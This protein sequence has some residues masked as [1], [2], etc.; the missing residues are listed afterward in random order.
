M[1]MVPYVK[2]EIERR[3]KTDPTFDLWLFPGME[4]TALGGKQCLILF[5]ADLSEEWWRQA[6]GALGIEYAN[7]DEN[8]ATAP[9]RVTHLTCHYPDIAERLDQFEG[10]KGRYIILPNVSQGSAHT[11]LVKGGHGEFSRMKYVG[12]YLDNCQTI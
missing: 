2:A 7:V 3:E 8:A 4:L 5:D 6:Q 12:G 10:L 9:P 1:V 11:V